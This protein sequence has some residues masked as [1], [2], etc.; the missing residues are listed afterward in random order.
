MNKKDRVVASLDIGTTKVCVAIGVISSETNQ[1]NIVGIGTVPSI[2]MRKGTVVNIE[3]TTEAIMKA[4]EEAELMSG[5][6]ISDVWIGVGGQH[7]KSFDSKGMVAVR[8]NEVGASDIQR[9]IEAAKAVAV[10]ADREVLHVLPR[11]YKI[12]D[13]SE[14]A[15]PIGMS[16]VR[17]ESSVHIITGSRT[18]IQNAVK[19]TERAGLKVSGL[20]LEQ[21]ASS[22]VVLSQDEKE[23]GVAVVDLGGG[24]CHIVIYVQGSVAYTSVIPVG[25]THVTNDIAVGLR[26]PQA[27]AEEIKR[28]YGCALA[29]LINPDETIEVEGVGGRAE[30][31]IMRR[32]L[33]DVIEPRI[34]ET[35]NFVNNEIKKSGLSERL[36]AGIVLTG[37]ASQMD[38]LIELGEFIFDLPVRLGKPMHF[39][40]LT[41][42]VSS[43]A[44][45]TV[46]GVLLHGAENDKG[47]GTTISTTTSGFFGQI[48]NRLKNFIDDAF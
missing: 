39:G 16:G 25:G 29:S 18:A 12:D 41:D 20:V 8:N 1:I 2:G 34:E 19:C 3:A 14:I 11:G 13:Q 4:R 45:S 7:I 48:S 46:L 30:R 47:K 27:T 31:T 32:V 24:T 33:C 38:G 6:R 22:K 44:Y 21:L 43:P 9:V 17:L 36:G 40:G 26:T 5:I 42:V 35:L 37:G 10:P 23:L 28:K 15:D